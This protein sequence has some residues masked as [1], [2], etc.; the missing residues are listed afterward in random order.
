MLFSLEQVLEVAEPEV[1]CSLSSSTSTS[2][3]V[4]ST[5]A[6]SSMARDFPGI[7]LRWK[8]L[9]FGRL[10]TNVLVA[11]SHSTTNPSTSS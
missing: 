9:V 2:S 10:R 6:T 1:G 4:L 7:P 5:N 8:G 11:S 3:D